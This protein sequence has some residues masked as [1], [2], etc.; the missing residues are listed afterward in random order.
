MHKVRILCLEDNRQDAELIVHQLSEMPFHPQVDV[1]ET[2]DSYRE[3]VSQQRFDLILSDYSIP[4]FSGIEALNIARNVAPDTPFIFFSGTIGEDAAIDSL[5]QGATDYV[6][7]QRPARLKPAIQ[8]ALELAELKRE[9]RSFQDS[10]RFQADILKSVSEGVIATDSAGRIVFWN[11]G[12]EA[13]FGKSTADVMM[14][15]VRGLGIEVEHGRLDHLLDRVNRSGNVREL[16]EC[17]R[18]GGNHPIWV[19]VSARQFADSQGAMLGYLLIASDV[20]EQRNNEEK[21]L[22]L[23]AELEARVAARTAALAEANE[24]LQKFGYSVSHDL[25]APLRAMAGYAKILEEDFTD[26]LGDE[27]LRLVGR[28]ANAAKRMDQIGQ[29]LLRLARLSAAPLDV[30][31]INISELAGSIAA[32]LIEASPDRNVEWSIEQ[33]L[34]VVADAALLRS[35]LENLLSNA[36]KFSAHA[37]PGTI[38]VGQVETERGI[39]FFVKDNGV[40]FDSASAEQIFEPFR[41]MHRE[42]E[43]PGLGVGLSTAARIAKRHGGD[44]WATGEVGRGATIYFTLAP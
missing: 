2:G 39:A 10:L 15:D 35:L 41:R 27:G 38:E 37:T 33:H 20:T 18:P 22:Q 16:I 23:N 44:M 6:V 28:I 1:V 3:R 21:I 8:R 32:E 36:W 19:S 31:P 29:G 13:I 12:A 40:G 24:E 30:S 14:Q 7:K 25:K 5:I 11:Q 34:E 4:G 43:F 17:R 42:D 9:Q 26:A